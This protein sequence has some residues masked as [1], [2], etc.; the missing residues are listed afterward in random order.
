M[1]RHAHPPA[2]RPRRARRRA[3]FSLIELV[4]AML[5]MGIV[6][7]Y[8]MET[9]STN[10]DAYQVVEQV[11]ETQQNMRAVADLIERDLRHAG[12][13]VQAA[14]AACG[15]DNQN[16]SDVLYVSDASVVD[17]GNRT[18]VDNAVG[19]TN[20]G[21]GTGTQNFGGL[22]STVLDGAATYDTDG[23][24][25]ADSDFQIG[26][27]IIV[28]DRNDASRGTACGEVLAIGASNV[29]ASIDSA[30]LGPA[31]GATDIAVVP[32][33]RYFVD[34]AGVLTRDGLEIARDVDDLQVAYFVD[35]NDDN[36]EQPNET[37]G[38]G[39]GPDYVS[40]NVDMSQGREI[41]V[42][43][44]LRTRVQD[45]DFTDGQ[46]Q[47]TLNRNPVA[48]NDG[49]RRRVYTSRELLRNLVMR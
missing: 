23:N 14:G 35:L 19:T 37:F 4:I 43:L 20:N 30:G 12:F 46:F 31:A 45:L 16:A 26:G 10:Q 25:A 13:M 21:T 28:F 47:T 27:G 39:V 17:P 6:M 18:S 7:I 40:G 11:S 48:G 41:L 42:N 5:V 2:P 24:G 36:V 8:A 15:L 49:F 22:T 38:D 34:A 9:F 3:G 32:A 33:H 1:R 44:V 29:Q